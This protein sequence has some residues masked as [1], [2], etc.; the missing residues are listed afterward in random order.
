MGYDF[1][2]DVGRRAFLDGGISKEAQIYGR[3][4]WLILDH[5]KTHCKKQPLCSNCPFESVC[6]KII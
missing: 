4:H 3:Y 6:Q 5:G 2:N 1:I